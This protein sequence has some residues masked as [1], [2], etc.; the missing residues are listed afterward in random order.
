[1]EGA[2]KSKGSV[3]WQKNLVSWSLMERCSESPVTYLREEA[4]KHQQ[5]GE[6][7]HNLVIEVMQNSLVIKVEKESERWPQSS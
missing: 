5:N 6:A 3:G 7:E 1:M 4:E 2:C